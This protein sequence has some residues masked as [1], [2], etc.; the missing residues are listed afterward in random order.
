M[1]VVDDDENKK[2]D[3]DN[4]IGDKEN[5]CLSQN[6]SKSS[7]VSQSIAADDEKKGVYPNENQVKD[8][9]Q[10]VTLKK[11]QTFRPCSPD[12]DKIRCVVTSD[13]FY[14]CDNCGCHG[15]AAEFES[16]NSCSQSCTEIIETKKQQK[17]RKEK[18]NR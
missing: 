12:E 10:D 3:K 14:T 2:Q 16:P 17:A 18:E 11:K 13:T 1:E 8:N 7:G 4:S 9:N 5:M 15:L 6:S